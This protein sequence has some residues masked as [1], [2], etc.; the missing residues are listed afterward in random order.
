[1]P[2]FIIKTEKGFYRD[3]ILNTFVKDA[4]AAHVFED[5]VDAFDVLEALR[6]DNVQDLQM[7]ELN[8]VDEDLIEMARKIVRD[9]EANAALN[10]SS[11]H[12]Q[13]VIVEPGKKPFKKTIKNDLDT[14]HA[15]VGGW[16]EN[17][18]IGENQSGCKIGC[19]VNEEGKLKGLPFNRV[20][21]NY[22]ILV[23]TFF[24]TAYNLEG[25]NVSLSD[26]ECDALI[27]KF[28]NVE[29]NIL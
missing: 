6:K 22:D 27:E 14:S 8:P 16:I 20:I 2:N 11:E 1:M 23:G 10:P 15:I 13:V 12:I 26:E 5:I 9:A 19:V 29:V 18:F 25:D 4:K 7:I 3:Y 21:T 24:I 28:S 17:V